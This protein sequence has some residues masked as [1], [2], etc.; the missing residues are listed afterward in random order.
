ML[1]TPRDRLLRMGAMNE[2]SGT[3]IRF[4]SNITDEQLKEFLPSCEIVR[5]ERG[6][7]MSEVYLYSDEPSETLAKTLEERFDKWRIEDSRRREAEHIARYDAWTAKYCNGIGVPAIMTR[8]GKPTL[9]GHYCVDLETD[10]F[11]FDFPP[12]DVY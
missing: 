11:F 3:S 4:D 2:E 8:R 10:K 12:D 1:L 9:H 5:I 7:W 6:S